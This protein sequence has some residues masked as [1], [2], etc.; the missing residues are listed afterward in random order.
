MG[1]GEDDPHLCCIGPSASMTDCCAKERRELRTA[2]FDCRERRLVESAKWAAQQLSGLPPEPPSVSQ[3][4]PTG[5]SD[6]DSSSCV[7]FGSV[8]ERDAYEL[9]L[10]HFEMRVSWM[11]IFGEVARLLEKIDNY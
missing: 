9:A 5:D 1:R 11:V 6:R 10:C 2:I 8:A 3:A 4:H 7:P